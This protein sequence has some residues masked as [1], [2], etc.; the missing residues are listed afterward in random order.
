MRGVSWIVGALCLLVWGCGDDEVVPSGPVSR[1]LEL[2]VSVP[3]LANPEELASQPIASAVGLFSRDLAGNVGTL[4][5]NTPAAYN[6]Y[7]W[8]LKGLESV[9]LGADSL[10]VYGYYP[11]DATWAENEE[12]VVVSGN[13]DYLYGQ[14]DLMNRGYIHVGQPLAHLK[15]NH[16]LACLSFDLRSILQQGKRVTKVQLRGNLVE[17]R[18]VGRAYLNIVTGELSPIASLTTTLTAEISRD[19]SMATLYMIPCE[20]VEIWIGMEINGNMMWV[21]RKD[22]D[23]ATGKLYNFLLDYD[24]KEEN[25]VIREMKIEDWNLGPEVDLGDQRV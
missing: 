18:P 15:M 25:M 1:S 12:L 14:H 4:L 20:Q 5:N 17:D 16:A 10:T 9:Q 24:V 2:Q 11:Y 13:T 22:F 19:G 23:M 7:K 21:S 6:G 8:Y 3:S